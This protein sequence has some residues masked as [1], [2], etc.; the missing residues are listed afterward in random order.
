MPPEPG[1]PSGDP[2][3][4]PEGVVSGGESAPELP[5]TEGPVLP[6]EP[7]PPVVA[8]APGSTCPRPPVPPLPPVPV[9]PPGPGAAAPLP[10]VAPSSVAPSAPAPSTGTW[11]PGS[12]TPVPAGSDPKSTP[13]PRSPP[14]PLPAPQ[15]VSRAPAASTATCASAQELLATN[16]HRSMASPFLRPFASHRWLAEGRRYRA[17][18]SCYSSLTGRHGE[19]HPPCDGALYPGARGFPPPPLHLRSNIPV[20]VRVAI[21][22]A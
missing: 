10:K 17:R 22:R 9:D 19:A 15:P 18:R 21:L 8:G 6:G 16:K 20:A 5:P 2:E 14:S 7:P 11:P 4:P 3:A 1:C 13:D 12:R